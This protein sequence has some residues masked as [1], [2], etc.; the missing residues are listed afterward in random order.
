MADTPVVVCRTCGHRYLEPN[1]TAEP[2][3]PAVAQFDPCRPCTGAML[4]VREKYR[5]L[6][7]RSFEHDSMFDALVCYFCGGLLADTK[8]KVRLDPPVGTGV[9]H[10]P[11]AWRGEDAV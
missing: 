6:H 2:G 3:N 4:R 5:H 8:G 11:A 9:P 1:P 10:T 7:P